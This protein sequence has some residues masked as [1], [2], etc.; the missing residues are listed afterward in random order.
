[1]DNGIPVESERDLLIKIA[2]D[3]KYIKEDI[4]EIKEMQKSL[5]DRISSLER[6][7]SYILGFSAAIALVVSLII[8]LWRG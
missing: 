1:M 2:T 5:D 8:S 4:A 7:R 3:I 6:W